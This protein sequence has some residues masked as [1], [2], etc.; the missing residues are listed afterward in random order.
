MRA[1]FEAGEQNDVPVLLGSNADEASALFPAQE[2]SRGDYEEAMRAEF[3]EHADALLAAYAPTADESPK[4][5]AE[6]VRS[7]Q[8]FAWP[9]RTWAR[10]VERGGNDAYLYYFSQTPPVFLLYLPN[11]PLLEVAGGRRSY[12]AYHSGDLAYVFGNV[13]RGRE[14]VG[15]IGSGALAA[16]VDLLVELREDGRP[17]RRGAPRVAPLRDRHGPGD[18][19]RSAHRPD[20]RS[21]QRSSR[22]LGPYLPAVT[23]ARYLSRRA[24][25][26][27]GPYRGADPCSPRPRRGDPPWSPVRKRPPWSPR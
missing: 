4:R 10:L 13:G 27:A 3:G 9:M 24:G 1:I 23:T 8:I 18:G 7:D 2:Q 12:G 19:A 14:R 25:T 11:L 22:R 15:R 20:H 5:A 26:E 21:P 16:D 17:E 6:A